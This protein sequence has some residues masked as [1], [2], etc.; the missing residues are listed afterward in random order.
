MEITRPKLASLAVAAL[1]AIAVL[2]VTNA[3][4]GFL[5]GMVQL[6]PLVLIWFDEELGD[7][8]NSR[9]PSYGQGIDTQSPAS[10]VAA[11]GWI[12]LVAAPILLLCLI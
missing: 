2:L 5:C 11:L 10:A 9:G 12:G 7:F 8:T 6:A 1:N 3:A 4:G